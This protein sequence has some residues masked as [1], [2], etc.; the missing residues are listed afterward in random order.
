MALVTCPECG[1]QVSSSA[2]SCPNCGFA[3][4]KAFDTKVRISIDQN[5][6]V[7]GCIF[8]F[9]DTV[10]RAD[11]AQGRAGSTLEIDLS[12]TKNVWV[13]ASHTRKSISTGVNVKLEP[14]ERYK[15]S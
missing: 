8:Y 15:L 14:G 1:K 10:T 13:T 2:K 4:A 7:L 12:E 5:P 3:V 6:S 9:M 11:I